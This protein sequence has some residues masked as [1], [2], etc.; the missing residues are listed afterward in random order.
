MI[1]QNGVVCEQGLPAVLQ[2]CLRQGG[3]PGGTSVPVA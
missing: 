3:L 1:A 2:S